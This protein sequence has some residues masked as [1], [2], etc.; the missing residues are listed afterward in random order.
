MI[1]FFLVLLLLLDILND[2]GFFSEGLV[3]RRSTID[4]APVSKRHNHMQTGCD[5]RMCVSYLPC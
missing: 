5:V 4:I 2:S 1:V 3:T